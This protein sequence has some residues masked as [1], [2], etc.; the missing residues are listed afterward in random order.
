MKG[1]GW[2]YEFGDCVNPNPPLSTFV[3]ENASSCTKSSLQLRRGICSL[4]G[5]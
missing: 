5:N 4:D 1:V 2:R 3:K